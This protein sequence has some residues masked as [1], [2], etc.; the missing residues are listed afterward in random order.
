MSDSEDEQNLFAHDLLQQPISD[1]GSDEANMFAH[2]LLTPGYTDRKNSSVLR[3][4]GP[5]RPPASPPNERDTPAEKKVKKRNKRRRERYVEK[6]VE[7]GMVKEYKEQI[8]QGNM[9]QADQLQQKLITTTTG[10]KIFPS[11]AKSA[12]NAVAATKL[13]ENIKNNINANLKPRSKHRG[14]IA[15]RVCAGL[16]PQFCASALGFSP[17]YNRQARKRDLAMQIPNALETESRTETGRVTTSDALTLEYIKYL[18]S[19]SAIFSGAKTGTLTLTMTMDR[20]EAELYAEQPA[21]I[22]RAVRQDPT[23]RPD[24]TKPQKYLTRRQMDVLAAEHA[25]TQVGFSDSEEYKVRLEAELQ[26]Y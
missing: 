26:R 3:K 5:G 13:A 19:R 8:L 21:I 17:S 23:M 2:D 1:S 10:K 16:P 4:P 6:K 18:E 24:V 14:S 9:S 12:S 7:T 15:V 22:R 25:T 20:L 11:A